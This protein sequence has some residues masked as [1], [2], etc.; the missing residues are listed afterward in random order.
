MWSH[1][2]EVALLLQDI[3]QKKLAKRYLVKALNRFTVEPDKNE[4]NDSV[5]HSSQARTESFIIYK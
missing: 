3:Q 4:K 1:V 5:R 2:K